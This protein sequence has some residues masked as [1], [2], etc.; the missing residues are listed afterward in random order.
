MKHSLQNSQLSLS[1][2]T[3]GAELS[4]IQSLK[5]GTEY[6]WQADPAFWANHAPVLFPIVGGLK[7]NT[8]FHEGNAYQ[9][10]R[11]GFVRYN[12]KVALRNQ[13]V[14]FLTF[15]LRY[16]AET[17][18]VYPFQ[19]DFEITFRLTNNRITV[20]HQVKNLGETEMY[21][22]LGAHPAFVCPLYAGESYS[23]YYLEFDQPETVQTWVLDEGGQIAE[24]GSLMMEG[25]NILPLHEHLFDNDALIFKDATSRSVS[26]KSRKSSTS[27]LTV[28]IPGLA[29][30]RHLGEA[31]SSFCL[32]RTLAWP[33]RSCRIMTNN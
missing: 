17:L 18:K 31:R 6:L 24:E 10:P 9:L 23:D 29:L 30:S 11:H 26:L 1:V 27:A 33:S 14:D 15:G 22:S 13:G 8:Y 16:D 3:T 2:K 19:F 12:E 5:T 28:T 20:A 25:T 7:D 4:S 32:H 21:F